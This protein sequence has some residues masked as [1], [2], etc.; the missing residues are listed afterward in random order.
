MAGSSQSLPPA[1]LLLVFPDPALVRK[2]VRAGLDVR[3][4]LDGRQRAEDIPLPADRVVGVDGRGDR[5]TAVV[6][7]ELIGEHRVTHVLDGAGFPLRDPLSAAGSDDDLFGRELVPAWQSAVGEYTAATVD[8]V[9]KVV[10]D[11]GWHAVIRADRE[12]VV[13]RSGEDVDEWARAR[14]P[15][16]GPFAV[17]KLDSDPEVVVS[18]LTVDGMHRV[19]AITER[20]EEAGARSY[21]YP[22]SLPELR[23]VR[24]RAAVT[25][26]LDLVGH[27]FG[28][29][30]TRVALTGPEPRVLRSRPCFSVDGISELI[31]VA[32]G[33]DVATELFRALAGALLQP[34]R[35]RWFAGTRSSWPPGSPGGD[36]EPSVFAEGVSPEVVRERLDEA[37]APSD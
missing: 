17:E 32:T 19:I 5:G 22:A 1:R 4:V 9:R 30:Q 12:Q 13:V 10:G 23:M 28:P 37:G 34:P 18:T 29:A 11:L 21:V 35:P 2:A 26:M 27:E 7:R 16:S 3:V 33:F 24:V 14:E 20:V 8:E 25:S 36:R 31:E 6:V 15:H